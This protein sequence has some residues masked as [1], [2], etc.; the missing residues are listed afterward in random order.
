M[1][2]I[3]RPNDRTQGVLRPLA[4]VSLKAYFGPQKT[5]QWL[6]Q[7]KDLARAHPGVQVIVFPI[8]T[9]LQEA[10]DQLEPYAHVGSQSVSSKPE[11]AFTGEVPATYL[12]EV[13]VTYAEIAHA[14]RRRYFQESDSYFADQIGQSTR[15]GLIPLVC[16]GEPDL[17]DPDKSA[18]HCI[19]R[20]E[21]IGVPDGAVIAYEPE[22][23][24]GAAEP[25]SAEHINA[26]AQELKNWAL[27]SGRPAIR[28]I[29]GGTA[30][31]G[32]VGDLG[33]EVDG[34]FL[35][36]KAHSNASFEQVLIEL[37]TR[38]TPWKN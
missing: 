6:A 8:I 17:A 36:R 38:N 28:V 20:L 10:V 21:T 13:G 1:T 14:E 35:G 25:A 16:V 15:A 30:G 12:K 34:L 3:E 32:T 5:R 29:Y 19:A 31:P 9:S 2:G 27:A 33:A 24:I 7:V 37:E 18:A 4:A 23:A 26:V 22:W 11:G